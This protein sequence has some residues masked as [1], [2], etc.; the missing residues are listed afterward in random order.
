MKLRLED[1]EAPGQS[2][3][4]G[5][6]EYKLR[7]FDLLVQLWCDREFRAE[8]KSG[9][10]LDI[11]NKRLADAD[12]SAF[13]KVCYGMLEDQNAFK[14]YEDFLK[15]LEKYKLP[16]E[17]LMALVTEAITNSQPVVTGAVKKKIQKALMWMGWI[18][19]LSMTC[20]HL[21]TAGCP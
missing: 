2:L 6:T 8:G 20:W 12:R 1:I 18:M 3:L 11:L 5:G 7:A 16:I 19:A 14:T 21:V 13:V 10:G 15:A 4:I 9:G 17:V